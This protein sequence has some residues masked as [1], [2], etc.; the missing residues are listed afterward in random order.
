MP[1]N[2]MTRLF[3]RSPFVPLQ[4]HLDKVA[5]CVEAAFSL[6]ERIREGEDPNVEE[7]AREISK[8]E[9][10]A[11]LVKNDI[12][13]NLPR[14]LFLAIDRGQLLEILG[15]QDSIADKAEDIGILMS[16]RSAKMLDSL[17]EP[18]GEYIKENKYAFHKA[19]DVMR[20]LDA[21]IESGFG[22]VEATRVVEMVDGVAEA[23]HNCDIMQRKLMKLVLDHEDE[24]SV[25]HFFVWQRL[26][27]EIAG[28][29][30][31]SEK[32]ANRVRMLLTLK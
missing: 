8:L 18:F 1:V 19:R 20:E 2:A 30:N 6:L 17:V 14:G 10:K 15:L 32:L 11:D 12:R 13:N 31:Y 5:D 9:H 4:L 23:E 21:L 24:L 27:H 3:G 16:L 7:T 25:G 29:S 22:G 26:L 28:I